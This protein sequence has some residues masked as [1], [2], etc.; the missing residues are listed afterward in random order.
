MTWAK[1]DDRFHQH[2]KIRQAWRADHAS[3]GLH[4]MAI[5]YCAGAETDGFVDTGFVEEK[6]PNTRERTKA[7]RALVE[8]GMWRELDNGWVIHDYLDFHPSRAGLTDRRAKEAARK[9]AARAQGVQPDDEWIPN[10]R[11]VDA[12]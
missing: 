8:A 3:I 10:G 4:V 5:T 11:P 6:L 1:L 9:A 7:V 2:W 12:R